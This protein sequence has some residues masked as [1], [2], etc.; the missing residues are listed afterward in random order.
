[1]TITAFVQGTIIECFVNDAWAFSCRAYD[2]RSGEFTIKL[3]R[4]TA[5]VNELQVKQ[6]R[7]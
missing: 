2:H 5:T 1:M 6:A 7:K 3:N 4:G